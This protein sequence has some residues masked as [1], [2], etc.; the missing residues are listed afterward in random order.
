MQWVVLGGILLSL[1]VLWGCDMTNMP[2]RSHTG[3]L[4]PLTGEEREIGRRLELHIRQLAGDIGERNIWHPEA[5]EKSALYIEQTLS[6]LGFAVSRLP[7]HAGG[8]EVRNLEIRLPGTA[9]PGEIVLA[10]AH[11]DSVA[12][13]PGADDNASGVAGI[14]EIARLLKGRR[15]ARTVV[16]AAFVNEEPPFFQTAQM[17][18]AV[19]AAAARQRGD[20]IVAALSLET[21]GYYSEEPGSQAYPPPFSVAYPDR[22]NFIGFVGNISSKALVKECVASF[23]RHT[24]FPSEGVSAPSSIPGIGWSDHWA[25]WQEGYPGVMVTDTAPFRNPHYHEV[26]DTPEQID[27][28]L[29][30]R[31]TA[32]LARVIEDLSGGENGP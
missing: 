29:T 6:D 19:Y 17:G 13:C 12:D 32:G 30:A 2:G 15:F 9:R 10:G 7:Y 28:D 26:T 14:L 31:V 24:A 22:G 25:F 5:L 3:P 8:L 27:Y 11:Y 4:P 21:I 23:R 18:S 1:F 16:L 20:K